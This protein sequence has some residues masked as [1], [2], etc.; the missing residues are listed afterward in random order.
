MAVFRFTT[1]HG[2]F[3]TFYSGVLTKFVPD[4]R[5]EVQNM[6]LICKQ[7]NTP[8]LIMVGLSTHHLLLLLLTCERKTDTYLGMSVCDD[9]N[10]VKR[11]NIVFNFLRLFYLKYVL[12]SGQV[13][14]KNTNNCTTIKLIETKSGVGFCVI[15]N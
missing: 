6:V 7:F 5:I 1:C 13:R 3:A 2:Y 10:T 9:A 8:I 12:R 14:E 15:R 4:D 11:F